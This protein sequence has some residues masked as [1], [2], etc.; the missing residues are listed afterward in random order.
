MTDKKNIRESSSYIKF[1]IVLYAISLSAKVGE[2]SSES[3]ALGVGS[4]RDKLIF[5]EWDIGMKEGVLVLIQ[6]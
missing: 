4:L 2:F 3:S 5:G 1:D 6:L